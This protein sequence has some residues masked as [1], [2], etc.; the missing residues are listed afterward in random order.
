MGPMGPEMGV[1]PSAARIW[2][3]VPVG[4]VE[5]CRVRLKLSGALPS[6]RTT[7]VKVTALPE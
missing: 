5:F 4:K 2:H 6:F 1:T 3:V 7:L